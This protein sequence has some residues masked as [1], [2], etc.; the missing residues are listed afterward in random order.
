MPNSSPSDSFSIKLKLSH[1]DS[2]SVLT[3]KMKTM[4]EK[5]CQREKRNN[6]KIFFSNNQTQPISKDSSSLTIKHNNQRETMTS[7][8]PRPTQGFARIRSHRFCWSCQD[9]IGL[10]LL[11]LIGSDWWFSLTLSCSIS[12][13]PRQ[14]SPRFCSGRIGPGFCWS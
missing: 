7:T 12:L 10:E 3:T 6:Q 4:K 11:E 1:S 8:N 5:H 2:I 14:S 13:I 9:R